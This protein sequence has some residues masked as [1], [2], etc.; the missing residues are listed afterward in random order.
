MKDRK[1]KI[2]EL[3]SDLR[4]L[5]RSTAFGGAVSSKN[6]PRITPSQ[7]GVLMH[8][9]QHG[10]S[11]VKNISQTFKISSSA[12]TQLVDGLVRSGYIARNV[13][14]EDRRIMTLTLSQKSKSRIAQMKK[15]V[16]QKFLKLF[17][18]L[19]DREFDQYLALNKKLV[20]A[21]HA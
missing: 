20:R 11:T 6:V 7:W 8:I 9:E 14:P 12:S 15:L 2:E 16:L 10:K 17:E 4:S 13:S 18:V 3:L 1:Q 5:R 19:S 21:V